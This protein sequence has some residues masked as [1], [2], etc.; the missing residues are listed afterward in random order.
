MDPTAD[1]DFN[2]RESMAWWVAPWDHPHHL[3]GDTPAEL[4]SG[5]KVEASETRVWLAETASLLRESNGDG[6]IIG[7]W[8]I[9]QLEAASERQRQYLAHPNLDDEYLQQQPDFASVLGR[10]EQVAWETKRLAADLACE[11]A[12]R[13]GRPD[14]LARLGRVRR[15]SRQARPAATRTRG[16]RRVTAR[17]TGPPGDDDPGGES[18]PPGLVLGGWRSRRKTPGGVVR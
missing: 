16:S 2:D 13:R 1:A 6:A 18:E 11:T 17:S 15:H 14:P 9:T 4:W 3:D 12:R 8:L 10:T 5:L 7:R